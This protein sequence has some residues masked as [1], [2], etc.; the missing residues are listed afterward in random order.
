IPRSGRRTGRCRLR[1]RWIPSGCWTMVPGPSC[2]VSGPMRT[3]R[4]RRPRRANTPG[5]PSEAAG[6]E[7]RAQWHPCVGAVEL[8]SE[9]LV[10][11]HDVLLEAEHTPGH[12]QAPDPC[13]ALPD[14]GDRLVPMAFEV[15][16]PVAQGQSVVLAQ[17]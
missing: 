6:S 14:L 16:A 5:T 8:H 10:E 15:G 13:R 12:V 7:F 2:R 11:L 9:G 17:V 3:I 1:T 4:S